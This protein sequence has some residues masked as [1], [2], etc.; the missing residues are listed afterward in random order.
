EALLRTLP[1]R[2]DLVLLDRMD[3]ASL[4]DGATAGSA[5]FRRYDRSDRSRLERLLARE[6]PRRRYIVTESVFSMDG[7]TP[8]LARLVELKRRHDAILILDEAHAIGCLGPTGA[9]LAEAAGL[10]DEIDI[11]VAP[12]GKA[13]AASGAIV[14]GPRVVIDYLVNRARAFIYTTAPPPAHCA[15]VLAAMDIV[16]TEPERR[17]RLARNT[18]RLRGRLAEMGLSAPGRMHIVPI[19]LG[20]ADRAVKISRDLLDRGYFVAA[21]RPPTVPPGTARLRVSVQADHTDDQ[22][23]GLCDALHKI[24]R[25]EG[26]AGSL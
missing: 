16:Q 11:V 3:H 18:E 26:C 12:L 17:H 8:D 23:D 14:A 21:I 19:L 10:L 4:I 24:V 2:G 20:S 1:E 6:G 9:G 7:D 25:E 13:L 22:I 5:R 15:A